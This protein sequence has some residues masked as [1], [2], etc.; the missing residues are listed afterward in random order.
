MANSD[1]C[2]LDEVKDYMGMEDSK[3]VVDDVLEDIIT[4]V[5]D[6]FHTYCGVE[7]FKQQTYTE[8]Y[9]G[10]GQKL[11]F[12]YNTPIISVTELNVDSD[13]EFGVDTT[14]GS[15]EYKIVNNL[16]IVLKNTVFSL[17][18]Q[19][20]KIE[21]SAGYATIPRDINL[22]AVEEVVRRHRRKKDFD[23]ASRSL[24]NGQATFYEKGLLVSTKNVLN[25]YKKPVA[26]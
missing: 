5:S 24:G 14:V 13:W 12:V 23:V 26:I 1:L 16:Y 4:G 3:S 9:D 7:Q 21:Y 2:S 19:N 6:I 25:A 10:C 18:D 17:G 22:V 11:L 8:Y 15:D 20:V